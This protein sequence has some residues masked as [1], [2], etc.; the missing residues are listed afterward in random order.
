[1]IKNNLLYV[2]VVGK[3]LGFLD[4][5]GGFTFQFRKPELKTGFKFIKE[6]DVDYLSKNTI[7][8]YGNDYWRNSIYL[9]DYINGVFKFINKIPKGMNNYNVYHKNL[10]FV[11]IKII[12]EEKEEMFLFD[13]GATLL[14]NNKNYGI[15]F[16]DGILFDK[17][18]KKYNVVDKFDDDGSPCIIIPKI[19]IFNKVLKNIKFLRRNK[20][21]FR[22]MSSLTGV[23]HIGA[24]GGNV[25]KHFKIICDFKNKKIYV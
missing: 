24:I 18:Q 3:Y 7:V 19:T 5:G 15:S 13:T 12:F 21:S 23:K 16:L 2:N 20:G 6:K 8:F 17:L 22:W 4:T 9:F 11:M 25:L 14:K 1:M 10:N